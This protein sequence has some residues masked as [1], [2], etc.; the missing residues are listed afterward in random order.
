MEIKPKDVQS[1][2]KAIRGRLLGAAA[3]SAVRALYPSGVNALI[4][5]ALMGPPALAAVHDGGQLITVRDF[6]GES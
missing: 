6:Q 2:R 4:D 5:A 3:A 1:A